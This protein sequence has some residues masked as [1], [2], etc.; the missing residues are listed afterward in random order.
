MVPVQGRNE[1]ADLP[2]RTGDQSPALG[3]EHRAPAVLDQLGV[4]KTFEELDLPAGEIDSAEGPPSTLW[5]AEA[6]P[7]PRSRQSKASCAERIMSGGRSRDRNGRAGPDQCKSSKGAPT[8]KLHPDRLPTALP[9]SRG[10]PDR[11][12]PASASRVVWPRPR[13]PPGPCPAAPPSY[14]AVVSKNVVHSLWS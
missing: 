7:K 3:L 10:T 1:R 12:C 11:S 9:S 8:P 5:P 2:G 13:Q 4:N 14:P 6:G